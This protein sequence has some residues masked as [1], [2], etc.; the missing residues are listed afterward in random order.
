MTMSANERLQ[1]MQTALTERGVQDVKFCFSLSMQ[2]MPGSVVASSVSD[3]L[4]AYLKGRSTVV[5]RIGDSNPK[6]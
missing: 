3:F 2:E 1:S 5:D 6:K 4:D